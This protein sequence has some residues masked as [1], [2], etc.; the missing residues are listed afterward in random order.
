[1]KRL[2]PLSFAVL[3]LSACGETPTISFRA[4]VTGVEGQVQRQTVLTQSLNVVQRRLES[5]GVEPKKSDIQTNG[6]GAVL[7]IGSE[8]Q[9]ALDALSA[10]LQAPFDLRVMSQVATGEKADIT[11]EKHGGFVNTGITHDDL[12]WVEAGKENN[13]DLA[14]V[15]LVFSEEGR[16]KMSNLFKAMKGKNIGIFVRGQ[17]VSLLQVETDVLEDNIVIRQIPNLE[18]AQVFAE[19]VNVGIHVTFTPVP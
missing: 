14:A 15:R 11:V 12:I 9:E 6:S 4:D 7:T 19:D 1:M 18:L 3:L 13:S 10:D 8:Y 17:L 5:M 16:A 2:I